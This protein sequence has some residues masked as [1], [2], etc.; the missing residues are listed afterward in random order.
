MSDQSSIVKKNYLPIADNEFKLAF[1]MAGAASAGCYTGGVMDYLFEVLDL[2]ERVKYD[3]AQKGNA[4][5][6][7]APEL[8]EYW[9]FVPQHKV[10]I[11]AFGGTSAGGMTSVM[12][13]TYVLNGKIK[14]VKTPGTAKD[15]KDNI[16]YDSWV[17]MDDL[18]TMDSRDTAE[19]LWDTEDLDDNLVHSLLNSKFIDKIADRCFAYKYDL[20]TQAAALPSYISKD[21]QLILSHCMLRGIPLTVNFS[22]PIGT[23]GHKSVLPD[24]TTYEHYVVSHYHLNNGTEPSKDHYFWLN[25]YQGPHAAMLCLATKATGAF[26]A[27]LMYRNFDESNF[28]NKLLVQSIK[29]M[30]TDKLGTAEPDPSNFINLKY[31]KDYSTVSVDGGAIN[32]EP[33]REVNCLLKDKYGP[34]PANKFPQYAVVMIDPFPDK[35][36]FDDDYLK[37]ADLLG[38]GPAILR[39]LVDQAR[40]KRR[41]LLENDSDSS[42]RSIIFP[43][44]WKKR[45]AGDNDRD[46]DDDD[47]VKETEGVQGSAD[48][49]GNVRPDPNPIACSA[50]MAF[51]GLLDIKFREHDFFLGR[52]NARNFIRFF[53]SFSFEQ[54]PAKRHPIHRD[55]TPAMISKFMIRKKVYKIIDGKKVETIENFLPIIP[56]INFLLEKTNDIGDRRFEFDIPEIPAYDPRR[57]FKMQPLIKKRILKIMSALTKRGKKMEE[58]ERD[59]TRA[60]LTSLDKKIT[61]AEAKLETLQKNP[62]SP[63]NEKLIRNKIDS[64]KRLDEQKTLLEQQLKGD[65][66]VTNAGRWIKKKYKPGFLT[67]I[68]VAPAGKLFMGL[69]YLAFRNKV[70][71]TAASSA[72]KKVLTDLDK[73]GCLKQMN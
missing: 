46:E 69:A 32:N 41:E 22:T 64:N 31:L 8:K 9:E 51:A 47:S 55:W 11:D 66:P 3:I 48:P 17:V 49:F 67:R 60:R 12:A 39:S 27:G 4:G 72:I 19:K 33:Y 35:G 44:K 38:V 20:H 56:D 54:E 63:Q 58:L 28:T 65:E 57:L 18:D 26:P 5:P 34:F 52:N 21:F 45:G 36:S 68:F 59:R 1:T 30:V 14:P 61:A 70:A 25:P 53:F 37:P 62:F 29:R 23:V 73:N 40:V 71:N 10:T 50:A 13:A 16:F 7:R 24:H 6:P 43:R 42:F 2:W 15:F